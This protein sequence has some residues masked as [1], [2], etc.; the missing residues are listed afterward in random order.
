MIKWSLNVLLSTSTPFY[1]RRCQGH[2]DPPLQTRNPCTNLSPVEIQGGRHTGSMC[3]ADILKANL[4]SAQMYCAMPQVLI[5]YEDPPRGKLLPGNTDLCPLIATDCCQARGTLF[6][7]RPEALVSKP[8]Q[9]LLANLML[10][11][12]PLFLGVTFI[13]GFGSRLGLKDHRSPRE[14]AYFLAYCSVSSGSALIFLGK[15]QT[16][17]SSVSRF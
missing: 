5:K 9:W 3:Q 4:W 8:I 7:T 15:L 17:G 10:F 6:A 1:H 12:A 14:L 2:T 16:P 11:L 13:L